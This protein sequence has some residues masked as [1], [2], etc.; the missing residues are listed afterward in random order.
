MLNCGINPH[1][2]GKEKTHSSWGHPRGWAV[3]RGQSLCQPH[4]KLLHAAISSH[5]AVDTLTIT[6]FVAHVFR[7]FP[8]ESQLCFLPGLSRA[9]ERLPKATP[10]LQLQH[11]DLPSLFSLYCA[12]SSLAWN[13]RDYAELMSA[14]W[15]A[16]L[17][18]Y[19][20]ES[21]LT[22]HLNRHNTMCDSI[23]HT[24]IPIHATRKV[25][26]AKAFSFACKDR[27]AKSSD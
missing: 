8:N 16:L 22:L 25:L 4:G 9:M 12:A 10:G 13:C 7:S 2:Y 18:Q 15:Q 6:A 23:L 1:Q 27:F 11:L 24:N 21:A 19:H 17:S 26:T 3:G 14:L 20:F 5:S